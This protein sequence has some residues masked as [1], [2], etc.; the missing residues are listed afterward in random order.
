MPILFIKVCNLVIKYHIHYII[1]VFLGFLTFSTS[2][3]RTLNIHCS[4]HS[5]TPADQQMRTLSQCCHF[6]KRTHVDQNTDL[7]RTYFLFK[8]RPNTDP[9]LAHLKKIQTSPALELVHR[10]KQWVCGPSSTSLVFCLY[11][12]RYCTVYYTCFMWQEFNKLSLNKAKLYLM[13][14]YWQKPY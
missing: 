2:S 12:C 6:S 10:C 4:A 7:I 1:G 3:C 9:I 14:C 8:Y 5:N 11:L 13:Y